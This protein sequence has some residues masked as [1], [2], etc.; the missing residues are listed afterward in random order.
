MLLAI[1]FPGL[2]FLFRG[3]ILSGIVCIV[4]QIVLIG[5]IPAAIWAVASLNNGRNEK[6]YNDLKR[7][8]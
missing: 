6:R 2:S 7:S 8:D 3:K 5:W 1:L 4:L